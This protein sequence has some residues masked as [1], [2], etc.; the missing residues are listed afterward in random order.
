MDAFRKYVPER[1]LP[2][3]NAASLAVAGAFSAFLLVVAFL[4]TFGPEGNVHQLADIGRVPD[5]LVTA[6]LPVA[7][8]IMAVRFTAQVV[9]ELDAGR[10]GAPSPMG[11]H[12]GG[13]H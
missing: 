6:S 3:Y 12:D 1:V 5:W 2:W 7:F 9:Q 8:A 4:Y 10:T 11:R 13:T